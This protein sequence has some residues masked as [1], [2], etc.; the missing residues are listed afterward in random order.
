MRLSFKGGVHPDSKK[1]LT[2]DKPIVDLDA[3]KIVYIPL[4]QHIGAPAEPVVEVGDVVK[5]G[6]LIGKSEAFVSAPV[7]SSVSGKVIKIEPYFHPSGVKAPA[8]V[9]EN[10]FLE[11]WDNEIKPIGDYENLSSKEIVDAI[12]NAGIV[13]MGGATFPTHVKLSP[14]PEKEVKYIIVNGAECEPYLTSDYRAMIEYP[15]KIIYG[16]KA[17]MKIFD[18]KVGYIGIED[19]KKDGIKS[20]KDA[21]GQDES[22]KILSLKTK[23]PQGSE[24]HL[25][26]AVTGKEVP[27]G[28]LPVDVG[29]IVVNVD[30]AVE[31]CEVLKTGRPLTSRIVTVTGDAVN[32]PC[33]LRVRI[34]TPFSEV[35]EAAGGVKENIVKLIM[36]GPMMGM[37]QFSTETPVI[38]GTSG[39][40]CL[41]D[42][43]IC[44]KKELACLRCGKCVDACP[45]GLMPLY[46]SMYSKKED[47][48]NM[49]KYNILDC[50]ECG[51]C[52]FACPSFKN[53]VEHIRI[54]K[55]K[56]QLNNVKEG[57]K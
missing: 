30:T 47:F 56:L 8:V 14:P 23:Y 50:I 3:P 21:L 22:V 33:N 29:A 31:V 46:I 28:K 5:K 10:D 19:N 26:K 44:D 13:G 57:N 39:L 12:K 9:I 54:G 37:A 42:K 36:G 32:S 4:R 7:H 48:K 11:E 1:E 53:P 34:G 24:K 51:S 41:T 6:Q 38:K 45:M 17:I 52:S 35:L 43:E 49:K 25:I 27:S 20:L 55:A 40:L 15:E 16:L 18:L 2:K